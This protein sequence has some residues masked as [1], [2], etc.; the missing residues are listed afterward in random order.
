MLQE[1]K[2]ELQYAQDFMHVWNLSKLRLF[3]IRSVRILLKIGTRAGTQR[4]YC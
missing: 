1:Q 4:R 2:V 3:E